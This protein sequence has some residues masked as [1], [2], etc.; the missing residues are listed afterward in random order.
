ML[1]LAGLAGSERLFGRAAPYVATV[2]YSLSFFFHLI[3]G[4]AETFTRIPLGDP[5]FATA[6]D[7]YFV[8]I[9]AVLF[10]LFLVGAAMQVR[11]LHFELE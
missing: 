2:S 1:G 6:D 8:Q 3:P 11:R 5:L 4:V 10:A 7:P 9:V